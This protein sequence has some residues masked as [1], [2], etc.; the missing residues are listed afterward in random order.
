MRT[1]VCSS[2]VLLDEDGSPARMFGT[3]QD[4]TDASRAQEDAFARQKLESLGTLASGIAHDF[5]NL[6]GAMLAQAELAGAELASGSQADEALKQIRD[7]AIRGSEIVRQL[8]I[9][10]G[11]EGDIVELTDVSKAVE[12]MLG[13]LKVSVSRHATIVTDLAESL[14]TVKARPAQLRQI[15]MNLVVNASDAIRDREGVIRVTTRC[16]T[17]DHIAGLRT[18]DCLAPGEYVEM[19][20]SDTGIGMSPETKSRVFDPFFTTKSAGRGLGLAVVHG[21]VR[22]LNGA[23]RVI[24]ESGNGA[25]F[26]VL[27]PCTGA[28]NSTTDDTV[29][30][31]AEAAT[32]SREATILVVED[33]HPLREAVT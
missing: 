31:L 15:V 9:Y 13:L 33:E 7:V 32:T 22:N 16:V 19:E 30:G 24:S 25:T 12:G 10:A 11:K 26:Q 3:C 21:I 8:M 5:N 27:L 20:I 14:P 2:D 6:L 4:V 23:I 17:L 28:A 1:V 29:A 18:S